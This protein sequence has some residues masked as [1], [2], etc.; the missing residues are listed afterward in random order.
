MCSYTQVNANAYNQEDLGSNAIAGSRAVVNK[1]DY[2]SI[3]MPLRPKEQDIAQ[4]IV[5]QQRQ[6]GKKCVEMPN[7]ILHVHKVR[8]ASHERGLK[9]WIHLDLSTG[10][11]TD[12]WV[13]DKNNEPYEIEKTELANVNNS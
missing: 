3:L 4:I 1:C 12:C 2:A 9:V 5:E 8:F 10:D 11:V 6:S 13:T 7:R